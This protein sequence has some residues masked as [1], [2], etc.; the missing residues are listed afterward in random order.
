MGMRRTE[1][2]DSGTRVTEPPGGRGL[3]DK[4]ATSACIAPADARRRPPPSGPEPRLSS[5]LGKT[6]QRH[7]Q[8]G[9]QIQISAPSIIGH[10]IT[11]FPNPR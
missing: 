9:A 7:L 3:E 1:G 8:N 6:H 4:T 5:Q 2:T 11:E 10:T